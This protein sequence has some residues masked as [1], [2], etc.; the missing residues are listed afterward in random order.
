ML[1][2]NTATAIMILSIGIS[3]SNHFSSQKEFSKNLMLAIAYGASI[4]GLA[5]LIGSPPNIIFAGIIQQNLGVEITFLKWMTFA[6]PITVAL[7]IVAWF[8]L[9]RFK[10]DK[11]VTENKE[12]NF[13]DHTKMTTSE[14]M[15][16]IVYDILTKL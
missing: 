4:G 1:L 12:F 6:L 11:Y 8:Y 7:L 16:I 5:T 3:I 14:K 10:V 15:L 2:F 13:N 9:T